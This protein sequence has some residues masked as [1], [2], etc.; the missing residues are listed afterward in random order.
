[1]FDAPKFKY[2]NEKKKLLLDM[3]PKT[4]FGTAMDKTR[5]TKDRF[6]KR[7]RKKLDTEDVALLMK[8][9]YLEDKL[10]KHINIF[11]NF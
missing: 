6:I 5:V 2:N 8:L 1:M 11:R 4:L 10:I 7:E 9:F 3:S